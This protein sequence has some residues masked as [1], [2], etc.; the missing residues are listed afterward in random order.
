MVVRP[1]GRPRK[2]LD[3]ALL[4]AASAEFLEHGYTDANIER[5]A[6]A[7]NTTKQALY[8]RYPGKEALFEATL[9][10]LAREF[11]LDLGFLDRQ[12]PPSEALY[13]LARVFHDKLAT[14]KV[15]AMTRLIGFESARFPQLILHFREEV[16]K[17]FMGPIT[18]YFHWLNEQR[19]V[20]IADAAE[21]AVIF[22]TLTGRPLERLMGVVIP[23]ETVEPYLRELVRFFL[24]GYAPRPD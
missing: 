9:E 5:I 21:A 7:G 17:G 6:T 15:V 12:R 16:R 13:D 1:R 8:R 11:E 18:E 22:S 24:A 2:E 20:Q 4:E 19:I 23:T 3:A 14:P 10:H